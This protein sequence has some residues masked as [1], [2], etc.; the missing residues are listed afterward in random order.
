MSFFSSFFGST[1]GTSTITSSLEMVMNAA[2]LVSNA[3]DID[4]LL[5][6][7]RLL[8]SK[9]NVGQSHQEA[10]DAILLRVYLTLEHYLQTKEP[11]RSF[12][13]AELRARCSPELLERLKDFETKHKKGDI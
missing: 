8:T 6:D 12:T 5:D 13:Q 11:I 9:S 7:V 1:K 10:D 3:E 2:G 4:Q